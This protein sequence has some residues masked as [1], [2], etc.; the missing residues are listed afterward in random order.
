MTNGWGLPPFDHGPYRLLHNE[1]AGAGGWIAVDLEGTRSNRSGLGARIEVEACGRS[2][3]RFQNGLANGYSQSL[4]PA[5]FGLGACAEPV[6]VHV[7]WPSGRDQVI[8]QAASGR[9]LHVREPDT[10]GAS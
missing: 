7:R 1:T 6:T 5:H 9:L 3:V 2:Q 8:E 10:D 4:V